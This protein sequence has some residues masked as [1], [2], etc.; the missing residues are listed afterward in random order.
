MSAVLA[1]LVD[2]VTSI[3][4]MIAAIL[5]ICDRLKVDPV[6]YVIMSI[7]ATNI[8]SAATVL[9]NPIGIIIAT[10]SG[11]T[12]EDFIIKALPIAVICLMA[13]IGICI[14]WFRKTLKEMDKSIRR[15][16]GEIPI[17]QKPLS[18]NRELKISLVIFGVTLLIIALHHRIE[19]LLGLSPST[20][21]LAMPLL[22]SS[23]VF[24]W[25]GAKA[26]KYVEKDV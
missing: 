2:E 15:F 6:P 21:M 22:S 5:E 1:G 16:K 23:I 25:K 4:F 18:F 13:T 7:L 8:G 20:I 14:F 9:G 24:I 26:R 3:I 11:L 19:L 10:K 12:F 17:Q